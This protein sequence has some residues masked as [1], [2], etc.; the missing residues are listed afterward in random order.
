MNTSRTF[1]I[2]NFMISTFKLQDFLERLQAYEGK[3]KELTF[4]L[5]PELEEEELSGEAAQIDASPLHPPAT[6]Q[7]AP[8]PEHPA[9]Q[10]EHPAPQSQQTAPQLPPSSTI[11]QPRT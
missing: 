5:L 11:T 10:T 9:P 7:P 4:Q 8:Q 3:V 2:Y 6:Q 1:D